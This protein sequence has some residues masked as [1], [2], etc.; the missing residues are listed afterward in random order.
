MTSRP[1]SKLDKL[2]IYCS[3]IDILIRITKVRSE[4]NEDKA[5]L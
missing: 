3:V 1:F 4:I 2:K 5:M